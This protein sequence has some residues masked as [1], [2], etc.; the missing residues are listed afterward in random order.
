MPRVD[1]SVE[2]LDVIRLGLRVSRRRIGKPLPAATL[3][4]KGFPA[5]WQTGI[6]ATDDIFSILDSATPLVSTGTLN[7]IRPFGR[8]HTLHTMASANQCHVGVFTLCWW[9]HTDS[10]AAHADDERHGGRDRM[11]DDPGNSGLFHLYEEVSQHAAGRGN[12][13]YRGGEGIYEEQ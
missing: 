7:N 10:D 6:A 11:T 3:T 13:K 2:L 4:R 12:R 1:L 9:S 8:R 5:H